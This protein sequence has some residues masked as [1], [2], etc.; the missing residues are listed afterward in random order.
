MLVG[1]VVDL[2]VWGLNKELTY[3]VPDKMADHVRVGTL[4]RVPLKNRRVRGWV[5][6][7]YPDDTAQE[8]IS[9]VAA[10]SGRAAVFDEALLQMAR[11]LAR[12][13]VQP[14]SS[15]LSLFTPVRLGRRVAARPPAEYPAQP[16]P[17]ELWRLGPGEDPVERYA[18][19]VQ[20][21]L[22]RRLGTIIA[23]PEVRQGS[24]VLH[25]LAERFEDRVAV[26]H[27]G[28]DPKARSEALWDVATGDRLV[29]LGGRGAMFAPPLPTGHIVLHQEDDPSYKHQQAPY[30]DARRA[31]LERAGATG[32][33]VLLTSA[34]PSLETEYAAGDSWRRTEP[35]RLTERRMWPVVEVVDPQYRGLPQ[36]AIACLLAA[37]RQGQRSVILLPRVQATAAGPGPEELTVLVAKVLPRAKVSRADRAGLSAAPGGL[38]SALQADVVIATEAGLADVARPAFGAAV[39]LGVDAYLQRPKGRASQEAAQMLWALAGTVSG[40]KPKGRLVVEVTNSGHH[41]IEALIRGDYRYFVAHELQQRQDE[42]APPFTSLVRLQTAADPPAEMVEKLRSLPGTRVLGPAPGGS[43]GAEILLKVQDQRIIV[44]DLGSIVSAAG[45]RILVEVDPRD[46]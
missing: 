40:R 22:G 4:V 9:D 5:V 32:A 21:D 28:V 41:V 33:S 19:I 17:P 25:R 46:W 23:V 31:A 16:K 45:R 12:H 26:V 34:T 44:D 3:R 27:T 1:V 30:F 24:R 42:M 29:V 38:S 6:G 18:Q 8:G 35:E 43:L 15:F 20:E 36:R 2:A 37:Y 11:T 10:L 13:Y 7:V 14:L 39:A